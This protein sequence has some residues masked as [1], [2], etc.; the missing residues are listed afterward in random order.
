MGDSK[1]RHDIA[2]ESAVLATHGWM[3][4]TAGNVSAVVSRDPFRLAVSASGL[5]KGA[6]QLSDVVDVDEFGQLLAP[7]VH[8]PS[9]ESELH[10]RIALLTGADAVVHVH[11]HASVLAAEKYPQGVVLSEIEMLKG[12]GRP[13]HDIETIIPVIKNSQDMKEL[14]NR[15][16]DTFNAEVPLIIVAGHGLYVWG[17][18]VR[19]ARFYTEAADWLLQLAI[20]RN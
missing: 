20:A 2:A 8:K 9:A 3:R 12:I 7:S 18:N 5:D 17:S 19:Q 11:N 10:S 14:G 16:E 6:M 13:A 4:G 15:F 1:L